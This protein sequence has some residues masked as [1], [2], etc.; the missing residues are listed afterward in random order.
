[1]AQ[2][3]ELLIVDG[4]SADR[5]GMKQLFDAAGYVCTTTGDAAEAR[6]LA[7]RKF[8]PAAVVELDLAKPGSGIDVIKTLRERSPQTAVVLVTG[9]RSFEAAVDALRLGAV[10]VVVKR[11]DEIDRLKRAVDIACDRYRAKNDSSDLL[12]DVQTVLGDSFRIIL[13]M[14]RKQFADVSV[15]SLAMHRPKVLVVDGDAAFLKELAALVVDKQWDVAAEMNGGG[16]LDKASEHRFDVVACHA[17]LMDL[18]GSMVI[19]TMQADVPAMVG[20]VYTRPGPNGVIEVLREGRLEDTERP[21]RDAAHLIAKIDGIVDEQSATV[22]DRRVIQ[23]IRSAHADFF[24]RYAELK[25]H[26]DRL[27]S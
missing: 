23:A 21:L 11:P 14:G 17:E 15:G 24:R 1:M 22:R 3:D 10:D 12:R 4:R 8:F 27:L 13:E 19:K 7:G 20:V 18:P 6:D 9:R 26:V 2:G 25:L 16:A 5:D